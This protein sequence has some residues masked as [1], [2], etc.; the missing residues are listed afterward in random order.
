MV[1]RDGEVFAEIQSFGFEWQVNPLTDKMLFR[2]ARSPQL[3]YDHI[4]F[5]FLARDPT[6]VL[7]IHPR[8]HSANLY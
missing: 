4:V 5:S 7:R 1:S 8:D 3:P 6:T 2:Q